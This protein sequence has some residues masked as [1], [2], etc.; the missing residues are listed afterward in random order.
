[1]ARKTTTRSSGPEA[2]WSEVASMLAPWPGDQAPLSES[3]SSTL[4]GANDA[5]GWRELA[6]IL[7]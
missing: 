2:M 5:A 1:M 3:A 6:E 4:S 7:S